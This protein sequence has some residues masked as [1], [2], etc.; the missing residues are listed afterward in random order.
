MIIHDLIFIF[1]SSDYVETRPKSN[2]VEQITQQLKIALHLTTVVLLN[3][4]SE[5]M[6]GV[7]PQFFFVKQQL[8]NSVLQSQT[9]D[10]GWFCHQIF[11]SSHNP[12][13]P[14][15]RA[16]TDDSDN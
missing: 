9:Q 6:F 13:I 4:L 15:K 12:K 1:P 5:Q 2:N 7:S 14:P 16:L 10:F 8:M 3:M 11:V